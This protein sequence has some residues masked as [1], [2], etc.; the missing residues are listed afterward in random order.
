VIHLHYNGASP[1]ELD[2]S[3]E[4]TIQA[5]GVTVVATRPVAYQQLNG[6]RVSVPVRF[7][8]FDADVAFSVG[9]YDRT[10][11]LIIES[12]TKG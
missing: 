8:P 10:R 5:D 1:I 7:V 3:G 4:I 11:P 12:V 9:G 6:R 2:D